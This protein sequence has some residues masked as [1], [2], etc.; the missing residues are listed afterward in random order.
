MLTSLN[1]CWGLIIFILLLPTTHKHIDGAFNI[2]K[3][4]S[5]KITGSI[6]LAFII[7]FISTLIAKMIGKRKQ[8]QIV[9][10]ISLILITISFAQSFDLSIKFSLFAFGVLVRNF[11]LKHSLIEV[12]FEWGIRLAFIL[13]FVVTGMQISLEG[14]AKSSLIIVVFL[15]LRSLAKASGVFLFAKH[16]RLTLKQ[17][18]AI[19]LAL[20]P[21]AGVTLGMLSTLTD[22]NQDLGRQL[23]LIIVSVVAILHILGP[24]ATQYAFISSGEAP[25]TKT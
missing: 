5:Y 18:V 24:I 9:L 2:F 16:C 14:F 6:I 23:T 7:L 10:F 4:Y 17:T 20:T 19:S 13:L 3:A 12:D 21:M 11:D 15:I 22:F 1:N 8:G 25:S